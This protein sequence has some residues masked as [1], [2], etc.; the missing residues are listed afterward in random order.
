MEKWSYKIKRTWIKTTGW[1]DGV[2]FHLP[3]PLAFSGRLSKCSIPLVHWDSISCAWKSALVSA[4]GEADAPDW[5]EIR[6][7]W[8]LALLNGEEDHPRKWLCRMGGEKNFCSEMAVMSTSIE[9]INTLISQPYRFFYHI[10]HFIPPHS[11]S[12]SVSYPPLL[13]SYNFAVFFLFLS[14]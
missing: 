7:E 11:S 8:C 2:G 5:E 13:L 10:W 1:R 3:L 14:V 6:E 9:M 12:T 4:A